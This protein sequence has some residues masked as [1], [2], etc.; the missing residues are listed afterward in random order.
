MKKLV[1]ILE[2]VVKSKETINHT[3]VINIQALG[4]NSFIFEIVADVA[5]GSMIS[6]SFKTKAN[7]PVHATIL[8]PKILFYK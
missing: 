3:Y 8:L 2:M 6:T 7:P 4:I 1:S 5:D